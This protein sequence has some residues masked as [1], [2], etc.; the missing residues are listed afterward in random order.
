MDAWEAAA[1]WA[2]IG[3]VADRQTRK[4]KES[5]ESTVQV[6]EP[7]PQLVNAADHELEGPQS[8]DSFIGQDRVKV[9]LRVHIDSAVRRG[10]AL[11]HVLLASGMP[12]VGKTTLAHLI[13]K[14]MDAFL[15]KLVPPF[16]KDT[17]VEAASELRD[18]DVLFIDE[19]HKMADNGP[20]MAELLLHALEEGRMYTDDGAVQLADITIIGATTDA[21]KL[22]ETILDRFVIKPHFEPYTVWDLSL[23]TAQFTGRYAAPIDDEVIIAIA[24]ACRGVPRVARE[25][26]MAGRDLSIHY[27]RSCTP[28]EL[29]EF[30]QMDPD[31]MTVAHHRYLLALYRNFGRKS[32]HG[33]E[34]IAG[35][36]SLR[37]VL[38]ET[39]GGLEN[40]ER[41]LLEQGLID[42]TPS[43]RRLTE[44]GIRR[45]HHYDALENR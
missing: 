15:M 38:R 5:F 41:F 17:L 24:G 6:G 34:Y 19:I 35:E 37:K 4:L 27:E 3:H 33:V 13:A 22:P 36:A 21:G 32:G 39:K 31:G 18:G 11:D 10:K 2:V 45:A 28:R 9:Q 30:K 1:D 26:V 25:L 29:F 14:E 23:I 40:L 20:Q 16:H 44:E 12:G 8:W 43:G 7:P 42:Q